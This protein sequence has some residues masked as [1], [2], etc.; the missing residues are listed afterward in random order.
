MLLR[1]LGCTLRLFVRGRH[2]NPHLATGFFRSETRPSIEHIVVRWRRSLLCDALC[3]WLR[4]SED[5]WFPASYCDGYCG[6][7]LSGFV[8][9]VFGDGGDMDVCVAVWFSH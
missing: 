8:P 1:L 3:S 7:I 2:A 5:Q 9:L 4:S 6:C